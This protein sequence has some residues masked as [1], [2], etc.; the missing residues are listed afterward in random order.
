M[1]RLEELVPGAIITGVTLDVSVTTP[2][3]DELEKI[4]LWGF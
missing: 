3:M 1:V 2:Q 4:Y